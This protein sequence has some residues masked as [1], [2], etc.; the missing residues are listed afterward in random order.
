MHRPDPLTA[1]WFV[2]RALQASKTSTA[3]QTIEAHLRH[4]AGDPH[5]FL[6]SRGDELTD[7]LVLHASAHLTIVRVEA[8]PGAVYPPHDHRIVALIAML[9]GEETNTYYRVADGSLETVRTTRMPSGDTHRMGADVVHSIRNDGQERSIGLHVYL[10]DLFNTPRSVWDPITHE[11]QPYTTAA[12]M[13][14]AHRPQ[15]N[16]GTPGR[17]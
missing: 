2:E 1:D 11:Q 8:A 16:R 7:E 5:Q 3:A 12:Y 10:G 6:R 9:E 13:N 15:P 17:D 14:F 4:I